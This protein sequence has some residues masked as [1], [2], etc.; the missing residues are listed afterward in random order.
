[1][2]AGEEIDMAGHPKILEFSWVYDLPPYELFR[3]IT[4]LDHL[5]AK[6]QALGHTGHAVLELRERGGLFRSSTQRQIDVDLPWWAPRMFKPRNK[7]RQT[8]LWHPAEWDGTRFYDTHVEVTGVPVTITGYGRLVPMDWYRSRYQ[9]HLEVDSRMF[10]IGRKVRD[11]VADRVQETLDAE[12][13]F[14]LRWL[15][16]HAHR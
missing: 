3:T 6:A 12:H 16:Q 5:D 4:R 13:E 9:V 15:N 10:L 2:P 8:Q 7:F 1:V 11:F 14:R